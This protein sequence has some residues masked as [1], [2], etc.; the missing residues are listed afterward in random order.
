MGS[1][2]EVGYPSI[3][4]PFSFC[5]FLFFCATI[6]LYRRTPTVATADHFLHLKIMTSDAEF[7]D[8]EMYTKALG[9]V[10]LPQDRVE[11]QII[12]SHGV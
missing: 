6:P 7:I 5:L 3:H 11:A 9:V 4:F 10:V 1:P 2:L 8:A 12:L